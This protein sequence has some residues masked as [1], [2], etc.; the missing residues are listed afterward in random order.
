MYP[1][2]WVSIF[3]GRDVE[4]GILSQSFSDGPPSAREGG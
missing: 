1:T 2:Y 4:R 3:V